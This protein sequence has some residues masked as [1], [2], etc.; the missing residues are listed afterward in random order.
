MGWPFGDIR[1]A[2]A[3]DKLTEEL[4]NYF[5][6]INMLQMN[7]P[8]PDMPE[9][10]RALIYQEQIDEYGVLPWPGGL[11]DQPH[12]LMSELHLVVRVRKV[13]ASMSQPQ[14]N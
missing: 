1:L 14:G 3:F 8:V 10:P 12:I 5:G 2:K 13:F 11:L 4:E 7:L 9:K 6:A